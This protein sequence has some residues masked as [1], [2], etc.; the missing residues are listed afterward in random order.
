MKIVLAEPRGFCLGVKRAVELLDRTLLCGKDSDCFSDPLCCGSSKHP[1]SD[2]SNSFQISEEGQTLYFPKTD[3]SANNS[4]RIVYVYH[5]IVHNRYVVDSFRRRG[6]VFVD[7]IEEIPNGSVLLFSAHGVSPEVRQLAERKNLKTVDATCPLVARIHEE[8]AR[9]AAE[10]YRIILIGHQGH[11]EVVGT[12]G[13]APGRI[14]LVISQEDI[15][16]LPESQNE[17]IT[18]LT[19]TTLLAEQ[20]RFLLDCLRKKF[21]Q[22]EL[23]G[24]AGICP[25]TERHQ[26]AVRQAIP[27]CDTV[28]VVGS[29]SSSNTRRLYDLALSLGVRAYMADHAD[30][31]RK[32]WFCE[33]KKILVTSGA[34]V[35]EDL[36]QGCVRK[37]RS[38][39]GDC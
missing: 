33:T 32:D 31:L 28:L 8:A 39:F 11:D 17:K 23:S 15:E 30:D 6:V 2:C 38:W 27:E 35:P 9:F 5:E 14:E 19:Q 22:L 21:P 4:A 13:E 34:S 18:C 12:M 7:S 20:V 1:S 24:K 3:D 37:L 36:V 29:S 16:R 26:A 10:G 25:A